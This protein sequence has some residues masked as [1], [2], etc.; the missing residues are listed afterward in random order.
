MPEDFRYEIKYEIEPHLAGS[1]EQVI[2]LHPLGF[3]KA[4]PDRWVNNIYFDTVNLETCQD[5]LNGIS[6][7]KKFRLR[8]YGEITPIITSTFEVKIKSNMVGRKESWKMPKADSFDEIFHSLQDSHLPAGLFP[9][10]QNRY[11][12]SYYVDM[13]GKFRITVDRQLQHI[14]YDALSPQPSRHL[15]PFKP[16]ILELKFDVSSI[17]RHKEVSRYIPYRQ[18]KHSKYV[19]AVMSCLA[20]V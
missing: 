12:R 11:L 19:S 16:I 2:Q 7:R 14:A 6:E 18:T 13:E 15:R 20:Y 5:N 8:W 17:D 9:T 1:I 4:F 10:I 3:S